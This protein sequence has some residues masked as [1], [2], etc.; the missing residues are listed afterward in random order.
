MQP[1][2]EFCLRGF[3]SEMCIMVA[4]LTGETTWIVIF[5]ER[6]KKERRKEI[7]DNVDI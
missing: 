7:C 1:I 2:G 6:K 3:M 5:E 4:W